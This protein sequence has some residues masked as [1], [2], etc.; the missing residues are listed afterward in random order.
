MGCVL[1]G[2]TL[3]ILFVPL[4]YPAVTGLGFD[5]VWYGTLSVMM[6]EIAA[7]TPPVAAYIYIAQSLDPEATTM[8]VIRG[9]VPF[10]SCSILL[11]VLLV[12]FPQI[13]LWLPS[14]MY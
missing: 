2:M 13:A 10:Y 1:D 12:F 3:L 14:M 11:V 8:D 4:F 6:V 7:V 5:P 9:V